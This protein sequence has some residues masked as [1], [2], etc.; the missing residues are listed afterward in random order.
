MQALIN[1][2]NQ[3]SNKISVLENTFMTNI[4]NLVKNKIHEVLEE[5]IKHRIEIKFSIV[6]EEK[7]KKWLISN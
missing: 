2:V 6:S 3:L 5:T 7:V 4:E 1:S